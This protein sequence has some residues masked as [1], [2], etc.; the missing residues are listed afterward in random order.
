[1]SWPVVCRPGEH[2]AVV[3]VL[4]DGARAEEAEVLGSME[5]GSKGVPALV[6][7]HAGT[8]RQRSLLC[9]FHVKHGPRPETECDPDCHGDSSVSRETF[10]QLSSIP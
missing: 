3:E 10:N 1:M 5:H 6:V 7:G 4:L 2:Q 9:L 8:L